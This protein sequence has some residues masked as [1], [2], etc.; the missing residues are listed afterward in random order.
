MQWVRR[1]TLI[2]SINSTIQVTAEYTRLNNDRMIPEGQIIILK[3]NTSNEVIEL[4][5]TEPLS[6]HK[7][8]NS[9]KIY[10]LENYDHSNT[11]W[12][13]TDPYI[14]F[15]EKKLDKTIKKTDKTE[16]NLQK[17]NELLSDSQ[18]YHSSEH[19]GI[20]VSQYSVLKSIKND[21]NNENNVT[22]DIKGDDEGIFLLLNANTLKSA[23]KYISNDPLM[24]NNL[25]QSS[26]SNN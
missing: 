19:N 15:G 24:K 23:I 13:V 3:A 2:P 10:E 1:T 18:I 25:I 20:R 4:L 6:I 16:K 5:K 26:V 7:A 11:T 17:W 22:D 12:F 9:W 14:F 21:E 8:I